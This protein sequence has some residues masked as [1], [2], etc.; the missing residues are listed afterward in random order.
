MAPASNPETCC[1][2]EYVEEDELVLSVD[3]N[4]CAG[5]HDLGNQRC[6]SGI[7]NI[8][9]AGAEPDSVVLKRYIHKRYRGEAVKSTALAAAELAVLRRGIASI[10]P[11]S[12]KRCRTCPASA[13]QV[14]LQA[15]LR[16]VENPMTPP[17][18]R[19]ALRDFILERVGADA[20]DRAHACIS[21]VLKSGASCVD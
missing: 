10:E 18:S 16:L 20:C 6:F 4:A 2:H 15:R 17:I 12:D 13:H 21:R 7:L 5:A 3:C 1:P 8:L 11:A 19:A 14:L 9:A